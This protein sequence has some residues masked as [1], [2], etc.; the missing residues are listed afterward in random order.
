[1]QDRIST[2]LWGDGDP[3]LAEEPGPCG[4]VPIWRAS[5]AGKAELWRGREEA[6]LAVAVAETRGSL[7]LQ[8]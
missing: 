4:Q 7:S 2:T 8:E 5:T 1:M 3:G 6:P